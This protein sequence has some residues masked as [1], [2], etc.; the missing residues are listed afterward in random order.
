M[1]SGRSERKD[2]KFRLGRTRISTRFLEVYVTLSLAFQLIAA[3]ES[4]K[5]PGRDKCATDSL[6]ALG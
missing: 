6:P 5:S 3:I 1:V 2:P 4:D